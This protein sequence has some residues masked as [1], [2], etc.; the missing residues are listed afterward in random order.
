MQ[1][2]L[3]FVV[4]FC[5]R[6]WTVSPKQKPT[7]N[8]LPFLPFWVL[9]KALSILSIHTCTCEGP[10]PKVDFIAEPTL[11]LRTRQLDRHQ[12]VVSAIQFSISKQK[13]RE[14]KTQKFHLDSDISCYFCHEESL[15]EAHWLKA[16]EQRQ[17]MTC[18]SGKHGRLLRKKI[19]ANVIVLLL[20]S[21][22]TSVT[23]FYS[24]RHNLH[25]AYW[26]FRITE[27]TEWWKMSPGGLLLIYI[28]STALIVARLFLP[29]FFFDYY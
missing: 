14:N 23:L 9:F 18:S 27:C 12:S 21:I 20:S 29:A 28:I 15:I 1:Q 16:L 26:Q 11:L 10:K 19:S 3:F 7:S 5:E 17:W 24:V 25:A 8:R 4:F 13:Q 22:M 2:L 6:K